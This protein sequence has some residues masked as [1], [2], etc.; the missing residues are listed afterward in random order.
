MKV[1]TVVKYVNMYKRVYHYI[2]L[3]KNSDKYMKISTSELYDKVAEDFFCDSGA[4]IRVAMN[5]VTL[6]LKEHDVFVQNLL[7]EEDE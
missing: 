5:Y 1:S 4:T 7:R 3:S 2:Q 6:K